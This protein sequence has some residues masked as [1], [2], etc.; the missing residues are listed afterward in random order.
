M[1]VSRDLAVQQYLPGRHFALP[2]DGAPDHQP[3]YS[4]RHLLA[5]G[6]FRRIS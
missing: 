6:A 1:V 3:G 5:L 4:S 2:A